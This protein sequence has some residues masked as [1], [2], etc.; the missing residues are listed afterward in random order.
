MKTR[1]LVYTQASLINWVSNYLSLYSGK[2]YKM[3]FKL[4]GSQINYY[5]FYVCTNIFTYNRYYYI[6]LK[7]NWMAKL[8]SGYPPPTLIYILYASTVY[9]HFNN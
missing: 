4:L 6:E 5:F 8:I 9:F 1:R 7:L 2:S 3:G